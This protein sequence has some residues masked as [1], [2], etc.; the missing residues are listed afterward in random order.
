[1]TNGILPLDR[2]PPVRPLPDDPATRDAR[3]LRAAAMLE[4]W[5]HE[6]LDGEPDWEVETLLPPD[7][8]R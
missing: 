6:S 8:P 4:Q 5:A 7:R 1:V 3:Y 2:L